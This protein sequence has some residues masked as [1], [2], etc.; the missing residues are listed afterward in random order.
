MAL[1]LSETISNLKAVGE[2]LKKQNQELEKKLVI[3][4]DG[5]S[6][7]LDKLDMVQ[8]AIKGI[9]NLKILCYSILH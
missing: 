3:E 5:E 6:S 1:Q 7:K 4:S 8:T 9:R 2:S